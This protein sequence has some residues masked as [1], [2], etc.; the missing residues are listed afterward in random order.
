VSVRLS[1]RDIDRSQAEIET[2]GFHPVMAYSYGLTENA[3]HEFDGRRLSIREIA[4]HEIG[5]QDIILFENELHC[6]AVCNSF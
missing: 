1:S 3:G 6:N 5:G 2:S 4:G